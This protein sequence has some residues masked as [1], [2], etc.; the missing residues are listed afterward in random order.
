M[1]TN[2]RILRLSRT[3][4]LSVFDDL[5]TEN[6]DFED[7]GFD[8]QMAAYFAKSLVYGDSFARAMTALGNE[9][10]EV[11]CNAEMV[12]KAWARDND[13]SYDEAHWVR[14]ILC[15]QVE[16]FRPDV[17]FIQGLTSNDTGFLPEG[18]FRDSYPFVKAVMG[19]AGF[20]HPADRL[21][22][23]DFVLSGLPSLERYY[24]AN[25]VATALVYHGFDAALAERV[26]APPGAAGGAMIDFSFT[27][28][29]GLGYGENHAVRYWELLE[30]CCGGG[31]EIWAN[32]KYDP[33]ALPM[34]RE[35]LANLGVSLQASAK[36]HSPA[37]VVGVLRDSLS[38]SFGTELPVLPL[39]LIFP[40]AIHPAVYGLEM[41]DTL[42]RSRL[43]WN[44][45]F[46]PD[47]GIREIGN[48]RTFEATGIGTCML[49]NSGDNA[50]ELYELDT[51]IVTY[52]NMAECADKAGWLLSH[53]NER[54]AI[55]A[56]GQRRTLRDH[57]IDRRC[58][59]IHELI[60]A[61][62]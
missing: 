12:Q 44:R 38:S 7:A 30:L 62:I 49:V 61:L 47:D 23:I 21:G 59:V 50:A 26:A 45:H 6:P 51:E 56:A 60:C 37:A 19:F 27:G 9:A 17:I 8:A 33:A 29:T 10:I 53:E 28:S 48:M 14:Q 2:Y 22:G 35:E 20:F 15:A 55:A 58:E 4:Y 3:E 43:T 1:T 11:I 40:D 24:R 52:D 41:Y 34:P 57:S 31:L 16:A 46:D 32:E 54:A 13:V 5:A 18:G 39:S 25:N 42:G 36:E